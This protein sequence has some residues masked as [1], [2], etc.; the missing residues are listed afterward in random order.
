[1]TATAPDR[2]AAV[3]E[4]H[5]AAILAAARELVEERGGPSFSVDELAERADVARRTIFNHFASLDAILLAVCTDALAVIVD[6]FLRSVALT[7]IGDGSRSSMFDELAAALHR[8]DLPTAIATVL[9]IIGGEDASSA[10]HAD[11]TA[12][13]FSRVGERMLLE[14]ARRYPSA[15]P[16]DVELLVGS[17]MS[18]I[19]TIATHWLRRTGARVDDASRAVWEQLLTR[20]VHSLRSGYMPT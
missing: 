4:R 6:D 18:G 1:M 16:L 8:S 15:D 17:L 13:A 7:A 9:R 20:L 5:R 19:A 14:V 3:K 10:R 12:A 2:R 11:L